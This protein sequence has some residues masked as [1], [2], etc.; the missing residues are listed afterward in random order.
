M[1]LRHQLSR[2]V[3]IGMSKMTVTQEEMWV[4]E[5]THEGGKEIRDVSNVTPFID[6]LLEQGWTK[7]EQP[8]CLCYSTP[9]PYCPVHWY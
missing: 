8:K 3:M 7:K 6:Y 1:N 2:D 9:E 4:D 5:C